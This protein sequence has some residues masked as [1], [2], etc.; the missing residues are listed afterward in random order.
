MNGYTRCAQR[1]LQL[2]LALLLWVTLPLPVVSA[3]DQPP[4]RPSGV[5]L[6]QSDP[7]T[8]VI[9]VTTPTYTITQQT[10]AASSCQQIEVAGYA[11]SGAAGA[12]AL[13]AA[14][15]LLGVPPTGALDFV[16]TPVETR[17]V[18]ERLQPCPAPAA[19]PTLSGDAP[20][21]YHEQPALPDPH[22]YNH[23]APFPAN[24]VISQDLGFLRSQRLARLTLF[25]FQVNPVDGTVLHHRRLRVTLRLDEATLRQ[26]ATVSEEAPIERLLAQH[27]L[28]YG[29][30]RAWRRGP[31]V[32]AATVN[33][34]WRPPPR[35]WRIAVEGEGIYRLSYATL[36]AAGVPVQELIPANL[37]M[38]HDGEEIAIR[39]TGSEDGFFH[40]E[41]AV[42]FYAKAVQERYTHTNLYWLTQGDQP[43]KR[44][45]ETSV[46]A[47]S[48][49]VGLQQHRAVARI[50]RNL[51]Y[52]STLP[53]DESHDHWYDS[54]LTATTGERAIVARE[55]TFLAS[56]IVPGGG[57]TARL[58]V[59]L[60]GHTRGVHH[61]RIFVNERR[62]YD[63]SWRDR[64]LAHLEAFF[65]P[66]L[67]VA[68]E[69]KVRIELVNDTPG[70]IVDVVY[71]DWLQLRYD[72]RLVAQADQLAFAAQSSGT[73]LYTIAG[74]SGDEVEVYDVT[75]AANV[76]FVPG[77]AA[78][79]NLVFI[80][81]QASPGRYLTLHRSQQRAPVA[82]TPAM[83]AD[84]LTPAAGAEYL[85]IAHAE[86]LTAIQPLAVYR[87]RQGLATRVVDV[88]HVYDHFN[89]G[90]PAAEAIRAFLAYA[91]ATWPEP[92]PRLVLLVGDGTYD[93]QHYL[94]TSGPTFIPPYLATVD[95]VLGETATDNRYAAIIGDDALPDLAIGR[96][97]AQNAADVAA[98]VEKTIRYEQAPY[99]PADP[100]EQ[101][102][103]FVT[104][105]LVG[106]GGP[107]YT[108]SDEIADG[109]VERATGPVPLTPERFQRTKLYLG[110]TCPNENP[111]INCQQ[112]LVEQL[113]QGALLVSYIGHS[114]KEYWAEEQLF[115]KPSLSQLANGDRLPIMLPMTCLEG[116]FHEADAASA[117]LGESIVR[118]P[119]AGAV[120]SWSP[121]GLG[122]VS[123]HDYL[124]RGFFLALFHEGERELGSLI[125]AGHLYLLAHAPAGKYDDLLDTFVLFG[126][127]ALQVRMGQQ[128][129]GQALFLPTIRVP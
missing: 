43:G 73:W 58:E 119:G 87:S 91:V 129:P 110:Q 92:K 66:T 35:G 124:Q 64:T 111:A 9:E 8:L 94:A 81:H 89:Y 51:E 6:I 83:P 13:P 114:A 5:Q 25:P 17:V 90:R 33:Q 20:I 11:Q 88:Q 4:V 24:L 42:I 54:R 118:M 26:A 50:E 78:R 31:V 7:A 47:D 128:L 32:T 86:F 48:A 80:D 49:R 74:F 95:P 77:S 12:P 75:S 68:G 53:M 52:V 34:S 36:A 72:R 104:D 3:A 55:F 84:L 120:A 62:V 102:L 97:P 30:A 107:F 10:G 1:G 59:A 16:V 127:P 99:D 46:D 82:I 101:R 123:G 37:R 117:S 121:T 44:M 116:F 112:S 19:V 126:D 27:L 98:M 2:C 60:A 113:N 71:I 39:V 18:A 15:A 28:N 63:G 22:I 106:G 61:V 38:F 23:A 29:A 14:V 57:A 21:G 122:L 108:Y 109:L 105:N 65:A 85:I 93:P 76:R 115:N 45:S 41:D 67:L 103:L 96:F 40:P 69:N 79:G 56:E 70:Q 125:T 100:W